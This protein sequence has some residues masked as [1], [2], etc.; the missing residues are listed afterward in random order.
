[1]HFRDKDGAPLIR[2]RDAEGAFEAWKRCSRPCN[3][4]H[5]A[6]KARLYEDGVFH[7]A[8]ET[9]ETY[10]HELAT[11][12]PL[13]KQQ[14]EALAANGR[15]ILKSAEYRPPVESPDAHYPLWLT[16]GRDVH[17]WHTRTKT[18][19]AHE[20]QEA[21]PEPWLEISAADA[22]RFGIVDGEFVE[23]ASRRA[24]VH[25]TARVSEIEEGVVFLP[26]HYG[27]WDTD[28]K[29][30]AANELTL[31][32]WDPVSKQP[33]YKCAAVRVRRVDARPGAGRT[34][35]QPA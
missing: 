23:I 31:T 22:E 10:G 15:A 32:T 13:S 34:P 16:S 26:F 2:W 18:A 33:T 1:M 4:E 14:H 19:R 29:P 9:C 8:T 12:S 17:H 28:G 11:G 30:R 21:A 27:T 7:T 5:P 35:G 3:A 6:G 25:A 20:L 24:S